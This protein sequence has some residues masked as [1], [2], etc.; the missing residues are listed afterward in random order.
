MNSHV[1]G[2]SDHAQYL[3]AAIRDD[4]TTIRKVD[5]QMVLDF[6]QGREKQSEAKVPRMDNA[7]RPSGDRKTTE[8]TREKSPPRRRSVKD[9]LIGERVKITRGRCK[10]LTGTLEAVPSFG[11]TRHRVKLDTKK[12]PTILVD[13]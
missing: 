1:E 13:R 3:R 2:I 5:R 10:H 4:M 9:S 8:G 11:I 6:F 12:G 7:E